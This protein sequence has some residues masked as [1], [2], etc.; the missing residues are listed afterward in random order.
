MKVKQVKE[1]KEV[2]KYRIRERPTLKSWFKIGNHLVLLYGNDQVVVVKNGENFGKER[3][4]HFG[5]WRAVQML[6][7]SG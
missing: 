5:V 4:C 3:R 1:A 6:C 7:G 2:K